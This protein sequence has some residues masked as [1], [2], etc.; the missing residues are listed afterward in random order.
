MKT[1]I[2]KIG[3]SKGVRLPSTLLK[4]SHLGEEVELVAKEG[5]ITIYSATKPRQGWDEAFR[6][7]AQR[8]DDTLLDKETQV[9]TDWEK[10]EWEW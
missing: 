8:G 2:I 5:Q 1:H 9:E 4:Q 6:K 3:N 7:M 10:N